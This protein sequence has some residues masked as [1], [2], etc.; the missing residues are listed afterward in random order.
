MLEN[1]QEKKTHVRTMDHQQKKDKTKR[2]RELGRNTREE[3]GKRNQ[4]TAL[5]F[6]SGGKTSNIPGLPYGGFNGQRKMR[7]E[8]GSIMSNATLPGREREI[9]TKPDIIIPLSQRKQNAD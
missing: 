5:R 7:S 8:T 4:M 1:F 3:I 6:Q 2:V 9:G